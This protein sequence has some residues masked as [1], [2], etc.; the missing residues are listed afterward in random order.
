MTLRQYIE[1]GLI[2][3]CVLFGAG[4]SWVLNRATINAQATQITD[5]KGQNAALKIAADANFNGNKVRDA[6]RA[7]N[8]RNYE[9]T[10]TALA[11]VLASNATWA[12]TAVPDDV[13][14]LL[15]AP[16]AASAP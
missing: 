10:R 16:I 14:S 11:P 7:T 13:A 4:I 3:V 1:I 5:L 6:G 9:S 15:T 8:A 2:C 12:G